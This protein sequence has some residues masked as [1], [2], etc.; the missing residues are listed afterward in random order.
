MNCREA[1]E[2]LSWR[3]D[4]ELPPDRG[5][6]L[7]SHL[8]G[9]AVCR[10]YDGR[11]ERLDALLR[12]GPAV[13]RPRKRAGWPVAAGLLL[14]LGGLWAAWPRPNF[15]ASLELDREVYHVSVYGEEVQLLSLEVSDPSSGSALLD[16]TKGTPP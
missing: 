8:R 16:L 3:L 10:A 5:E 14:L 12:G 4:E 6:P 2:A 1:Q 11:L 9:C 13:L 15:Q 7:E